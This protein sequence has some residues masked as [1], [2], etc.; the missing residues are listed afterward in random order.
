VRVGRILRRP[1]VPTATAMPV[2]PPGTLV[3]VSGDHGTLS[4]YCVSF[5]GVR[6]ARSRMPKSILRSMT[7]SIGS[8]RG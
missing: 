2:L 3:S 6:S 4:T 5:R 8:R 7:K 1:G